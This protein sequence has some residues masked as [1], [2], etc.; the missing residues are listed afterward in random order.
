MKIESNTS[1]LFK[2]IL[3]NS[4][5]DWRFEFPHWDM[6]KCTHCD[7][8]YQVC[9]DSAISHNSDGSYVADEA[10]C[11]GCGVCA[12]QCATGT[13]TLS[14]VAVRPPWLK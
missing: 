7:V 12:E 3:L 11:K 5:H 6:E 13:I 9:P 14:P 8:C 4:N 1:I 10:L 2:K